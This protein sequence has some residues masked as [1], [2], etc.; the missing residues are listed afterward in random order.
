MKRIWKAGLGTLMLWYAIQ[1]AGAWAQTTESG[2][3]VQIELTLG[4]NVL[5][6]NN[7]TLTVEKPYVSN[8]ATLVP[9]RVITTAFGAVLRWDSETRTVGLRSGDTSLSLQIDSTTA[10]VNG[11][12]EQL[13][14]APE[15]QNGTTMVP[16]RFIAEKFGAQVAFDEAT[17]TIT[18]KGTA[19]ATLDG[20]GID[21]DLGKT[22]IGNS[23]FGWSMKYPTGL[24]KEY[25]SFQEDATGFEDANGEFYLAV[26]AELDVT[27]NM[28]EDALLSRLSDDAEGK[29]LKKTFVQDGARSYALIVSQKDGKIYELRAYQS[30]DRLYIVSLFVNKEENYKNPLKYNAYKDLLDSFKMTFDAKDAS[31]KDLS[32]VKAGY[33]TYTD[34]TYG[35]ALKLPADWQM[36]KDPYNNIG[37]LDPKQNKSIIVTISSKS[38]S[39]TLQ[40]W[41]DRMLK[42]YEGQFVSEY[43]KT[44]PLQSLTLDN[45]PAAAIRSKATFDKKNWK[46]AEDVF[47]IKGDYKYQ[48]H[49]Q[50]EKESE[51]SEMLIKDTLN[52]LKISRPSSSIGTLKDGADSEQTQTS[53]V[54]NKTYGYNVKVPSHWKQ[55]TDVEQQTL[56]FDTGYGVFIVLSAEDAEVP[57][58]VLVAKLKEKLKEQEGSDFKEIESKTVTVAGV[59]ASW[60]VYEAGNAITVLCAFEKNGTSYILHSVQ[61]TAVYTEALKGQIESAMLSIQ[62]P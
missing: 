20:S 45:M 16:L 30:G 33:R 26:E 27:E 48:I 50:F 25:Q 22:Q 60:N 9:L 62:V 1:P 21:T 2:Q 40:T 43:R 13:E 55:N 29:V 42:K 18:I 46:V 7:E 61:P 39:E 57:S 41:T 19:A 12:P 11:L 37:F 49:F 5:K 8:G 34:E 56:A 38:E 51:V 52:S 35:Y 17:R 32:T 14:A 4:Q 36:M 47:V 31:L 28:S 10:T 44:E 53:V 24:I 23:Y 54:K 58:K 6:V 15:L 3:S 59:D